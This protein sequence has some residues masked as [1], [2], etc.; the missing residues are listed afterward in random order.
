[1]TDLKGNRVDGRK[2]KGKLSKVE[3]K[4]M[5][6]EAKKKLATAG[7]IH[8]QQQSQIAERKNK[9][10]GAGHQ[11]KKVYNEEGKM[12]FSK[13]DFTAPDE[14]KDGAKQKVDPKS[15]L[16][17]LK[18]HK[19]KI[20]SLEKIGKTERVKN[21]ESK[22]A[23]KTALDKAEGVKV[24]D[25]AGLLKKSIKRIDQRKKSTK[26][27][28]ADREEGVEKRKTFTQDKRAEN[29]KKRKDGVK[30]TK[31]KKMAKRGRTVPGF[32]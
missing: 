5:S 29:I 30:K 22:T 26:K 19:E 15:A 27:K 23:W 21:L 3:K 11:Q 4:R 31:D 8:L 14:S 17:K 9:K 16:A 24:K 13:F 7:K 32:K 18:A 25:D 20:K 28:W 2:K 6:R 1:M 12:V 10:G